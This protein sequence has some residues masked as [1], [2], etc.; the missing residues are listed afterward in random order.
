[1]SQ[2]LSILVAGILFLISM[3]HLYWTFGGSWGVAAAI[4]E[5]FKD[6]YY[7]KSNQT[8]IKIAT[9]MVVFGL[10]ACSYIV[11][12]NHNSFPN[13]MLTKALSSKLTNL[14]GIIFIIRGIGDFNMFGLFKKESESLFAKKDSQIFVP[15]CL[16]IG[17]CC[18]YIGYNS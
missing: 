8:F 4:P 7:K 18:L 15:L 9:L 16:S 3:L 13:P 12:S 1:M 6:I 11:L 2:I 17:I 14:L 5:K 10:L